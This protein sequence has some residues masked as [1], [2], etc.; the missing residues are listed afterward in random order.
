MIQ[1]EILMK[2][3]KYM[4]SLACLALLACAVP[5]VAM[6]N[7]AAPQHMKPGQNTQNTWY[8][9]RIINRGV[10][11]FYDKTQPYYWMTNFFD[12]PIKVDGFDW[13]TTEQ[14]Y[15]AGK[16]TDNSLRSWGSWAFYIANE[17]K[18]VKQKAQVRA[19]WFQV[20]PRLGMQRNI[21]RMLVALRAKFAHGSK[22]GN[23]LLATYPKV[24]VE[25]SPYDGYFGAGDEKKKIA[26][27]TGQNLLGRMLMHVR[28]EL[29]RKSQNMQNPERPLDVNNDFT[30][31]YLLSGGKI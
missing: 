22:L 17:S 31:D 9:Q 21:N 6:H 10:I 12:A 27:G 1:K 14:Y 5:A 18:D 26:Q 25:D 3:I 7:P 11:Y 19:D 20:I 13:P 28:K 8:D 16:F 24:L 29:Y 30:L 4:I 15:Q 2:I 23:D